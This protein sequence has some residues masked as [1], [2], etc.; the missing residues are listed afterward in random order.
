MS[1][2]P[3][4]GRIKMTI[5]VL[6]VTAKTINGAVDKTKPA[7]NTQG[8]VIDRKFSKKPIQRGKI[9]TRAKKPKSKP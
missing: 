1:G 2:R 5:H 7:S 3:S 8:K 4:E 6:P 9:V